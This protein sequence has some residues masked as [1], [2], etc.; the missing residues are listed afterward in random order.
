[1]KVNV[2]F[3]EKSLEQAIIK[4]GDNVVKKFSADTF[5]EIVKTSPQKD[6]FSPSGTY[7]RTGTLRDGW[8]IKKLITGSYSIFN[9]V[10]YAPYYEYGHRLRNGT[11]QKGAYLMSK[12]V[13]KNLKKY[14]LKARKGGL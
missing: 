4:Y 13:D 6:T 3:N 2:T 1:M 14:G 9:E 5:K 10:A 11:I 12:A 8:D 7:R